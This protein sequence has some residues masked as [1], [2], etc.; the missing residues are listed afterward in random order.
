MPVRSRIRSSLSTNCSTVPARTNGLSGTTDSS[1]SNR[2][3]SSLGRRHGV[4]DVH[5]LHQRRT[6]DGVV[7]VA[8]R[9]GEPRR[10]FRDHV[11]LEAGHL[12]G[13][14]GAVGEARELEDVGVLRGDGDDP[15]AE[16]ADQHRY[17][18][19][20]G[21]HA[22]VVERDGVVLPRAVARTGVEQ[23]ADDLHALVEARHPWARRTQLE[24]DRVVLVLGVA[25]A[26]PQ[27][28]AAA[29][30][31]V[32]RRCRAGEQRRLVE[33]VVEHQRADLDPFGGRDGDHQRDERVD[34]T[35]VIE[36]VE[37]VV[38]E[39]LDRAAPCA[40][41]PPGR[42]ILALGRRSGRAWRSWT[43][44]TTPLPTVVRSGGLLRPRLVPQLARV[45]RLR[46][47]S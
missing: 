24:T 26:P 16:P 12:H 14:V 25:G 38:P 10:A 42:P 37:L 1:S 13:A 36:R 32:E 33:L 6:F 18:V 35:D 3:A 30:H 45:P 8:R 29:A 34:G 4:P 40:R 39:R 5:G 28:E 27:H 15:A 7:P 23:V 20:H 17:P 31:T 2:A 19:L 21:S 43:E 41:W 44:P 11:Q 47:G 22:E 9:L 46:R